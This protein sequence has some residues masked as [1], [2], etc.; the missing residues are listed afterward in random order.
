MKSTK[1]VTVKA[2]QFGDFHTNSPCRR[3]P[4]FHLPAGGSLIEGRGEKKEKSHSILETPYIP[5]Q[6]LEATHFFRY[7]PGI[8]IPFESDRLA[9]TPATYLPC[10][11]FMQA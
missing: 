7:S 10:C 3:R 5:N 8:S 1:I 4:F 11:V 2:F 9:L 6:P